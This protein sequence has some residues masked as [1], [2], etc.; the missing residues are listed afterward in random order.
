[1]RQSPQHAARLLAS[2]WRRPDRR[3]DVFDARRACH[4]QLPVRRLADARPIATRVLS[5]RSQAVPLRIALLAIVL[6]LAIGALPPTANA[7]ELAPPPGKVYA[8]LSGANPMSWWTRAAGKHAPIWQQFVE[9]G[10]RSTW[11]F[12]RARSV[13]ARPMLS[14]STGALHHEQITPAAIA[15]GDGDS[16]LLRLNAQINS[17]GPTYLRIM[18]EMNGNW[19]PYCAYSA[20]GRSR[21]KSHS[22]AMFRSAWRRSVLIVRGGPVSKINQQLHALGLPSVRGRSDG[23]QLPVVPVSFL[24]IPQTA[25][26]PKIAAN[27]PKAYWPGSKYVDW[28][29]TDFYSKF[30]NYRDLERFYRQFATKPVAFGEWA[31][32]GSDSPEFVNRLFSWTR[33]HPRVQML[34]YNHGNRPG[35]PY[36]LSRYPRA[37]RTI[38]KL[39]R[40]SRYVAFTPEFAPGESATPITPPVQGVDTTAGKITG[41]VLVRA[42]NATTFTPLTPGGIVPVGAQLDTRDGSVQ[43]F[44]AVGAKPKDVIYATF[45]QGIFTSRQGRRARVVD[46]LLARPTCIGRITARVNRPPPP[47]RNPVRVR[48][49]HRRR[50]GFQTI[51]GYS[52]ASALGTDWLTVEACSSTMTLVRRGIVRVRDLVTGQI[53]VLRAGG[54]YEAHP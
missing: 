1:M 6:G 19:N 2:S 51:G 38:R 33:R 32:W 54:S 25:G 26:N 17:F 7:A 13:N 48:E 18:P 47:D 4:I 39:V 9:W 5:A 28:V 31:L 15:L 46:V 36:V 22:T 29:G 11:A 52:S 27:S 42:P 3:G 12:A 50:G 8:G 53:V 14:I 40:S 34:I 43:L 49:R 24:W 30:P 20:N 10:G 35:G 44:A 37:S 45:S 16:Y 23:D 41:Q 21:G